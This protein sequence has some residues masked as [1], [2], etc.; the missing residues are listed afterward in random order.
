VVSQLT[1]VSEGH[2][3]ALT[4]EGASSSGPVAIFFACFCGQLSESTNRAR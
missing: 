4:R 3:Y 2:L 1:F